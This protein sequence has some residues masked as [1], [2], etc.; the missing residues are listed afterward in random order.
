MVTSPSPSMRTRPHSGMLML[1]FREEG[2]NPP[3][4][5]QEEIPMPK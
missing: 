3:V 2:P 4:L 1:G 5:T